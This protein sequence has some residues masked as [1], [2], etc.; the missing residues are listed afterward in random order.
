MDL[1]RREP[2]TR[3]LSPVGDIRPLIKMGVALQAVATKHGI[4][5]VFDDNG[6]KELLL[7]TLFGLRKLRREGDDAIDAQDRRYEMKTVARISSDGVRKSSLNVTTEHT[8]TLA[9]IDRYRRG[10]MWIVAVFE[11]PRPEVVY[12]IT[13][14]ALEPFFA[15]WEAILTGSEGAPARDHINNP[16][17]PLKFI[18]AC[19]LRA[20]PPHPEDEPRQLPLAEVRELVEAGVEAAGD[21]DEG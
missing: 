1:P 12:E 6:Y 8:M 21:E 11:G 15:K 10:F 16:K 19:G 2:E 14:A 4:H 9:N 3:Y 18:E 5:N 13:P 20:W 17:V 7:L